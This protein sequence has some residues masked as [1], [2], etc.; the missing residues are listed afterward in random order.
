[1]LCGVLSCGVLSCGGYVSSLITHCTHIHITLH[2]I[3]S[4]SINH[5][6]RLLC[7]HVIGSRVDPEAVAPYLPSLSRSLRSS[8]ADTSWPI[9]DTAATAV[10]RFL[11]FNGR[12]LAPSYFTR[13]ASVSPATATATATAPATAGSSPGGAGEGGGEGMV[14]VVGD[15][16]GLLFS[17]LR[18]DPFRPVRESAA[19][20]LVDI[21]L[22]DDVGKLSRSIP[23]P[24][25]TPLDLHLHLAALALSAAVCCV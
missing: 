11:R 18:E 17:C 22:H 12:K 3:T 13:P 7:V 6:L 23:P 4:Q 20:G 2:Y 16:L 9:R 5:C 14:E 25:S 21:C 8:L 1:M 24:D 10:G 19:V 15:L